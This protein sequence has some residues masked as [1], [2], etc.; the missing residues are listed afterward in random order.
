MNCK[1]DKSLVT[2]G[3]PELEAI[4]LTSADRVVDSDDESDESA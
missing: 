2:W 4:A 3:L 1:M